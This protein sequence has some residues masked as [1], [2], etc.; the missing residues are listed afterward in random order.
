MG[1][2]IPWGV[3]AE[4]LPEEIEQLETSLTDQQTKLADLKRQL[5]PQEVS[6]Y[7]SS[8]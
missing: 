2:Q 6:N 7:V 3:G 1:V 4:V 5:P 8:Q